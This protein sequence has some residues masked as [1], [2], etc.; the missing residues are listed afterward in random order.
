[1]Q[2][3]QQPARLAELRHRLAGNRARMPLFDM[4]GYTHDLEAAYAGIWQCWLN[5]KTAGH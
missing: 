3:A 1:M 2:L 5:G 4:A